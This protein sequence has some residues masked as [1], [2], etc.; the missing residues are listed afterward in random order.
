M[1]LKS[2]CFLGLLI[3]AAGTLPGQTYWSTSPDL[4]CSGNNAAGANV[5][6]PLQITT[7]TGGTGYVCYVSGTFVWYAAG[8][9]WHTA[10]RVAAP[11]SGAIRADYSF[12]GI[13]GNALALDIATN[14]GTTETQSGSEAAFTL[15]ANQPLEVDLLGRSGAG[16]GYSNQTGGSVYAMFECPDATT[17]TYV[18]PQLLFS[19]LP[20]DP[21]SLSVP[22]SWDGL[23][24][25][26]WSAEGLN[27]ATHLMSFAIYNADSS[28]GTYTISV[29]DSNGALVASGTGPV[30]TPLASL[31]NGAYGTG[32]VWAQVLS[33][34]V[35]PITLPQGMLKVV[36]S[37]ST[38]SDVMVLQFAGPSAT[39][40]QVGQ[41]AAPAAGASPA[42]VRHPKV[43]R[44]PTA[45]MAAPAH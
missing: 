16:P 29:Y 31:K 4:D 19:A 24:Q 38:V 14:G 2:L 21:W 37:A 43:P 28:P 3:L 18:T 44:A 7:P 1:Y 23:E 13:A 15:N 8:A 32:G 41:D 11:E 40:L 30:T 42:S 22:I 25:D 9:G 26:Q 27:D 12:V 36:I 33:S 6:G 45:F 17:C 5:Q 34:A 39:T 10:I 20:S 35:A